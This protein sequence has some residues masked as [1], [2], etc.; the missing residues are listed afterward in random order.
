MTGADELDNTRELGAILEE[1]NAKSLI[2]D[3]TIRLSA[4]WWHG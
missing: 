4:H 3:E 1:A 2:P